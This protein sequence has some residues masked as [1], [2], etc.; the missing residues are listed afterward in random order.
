MSQPTRLSGSSIGPRSRQKQRS[1][2]PP[3]RSSSETSPYPFS[4]IHKNHRQE[5]GSGEIASAFAE[6]WLLSERLR[7][8][9]DHLVVDV[10]PQRI[11][12]NDRTGRVAS[13]RTTATFCPGAT[14]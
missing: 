3:A 14:L 8:G 6:C 1:N 13:C 11:S 2:R 5:S 12:E 9:V 7:S 4:T 10:N